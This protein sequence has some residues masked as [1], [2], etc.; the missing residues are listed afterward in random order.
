MGFKEFWNAAKQKA[1]G[2]VGRGLIGAATAVAPAIDSMLAPYT[3]GVPVVSTITNAG[4]GYLQR[5]ARESAYDRQ[6]KKNELYSQALAQSLRGEQAK[7]YVKERLGKRGFGAKMLKG[8]A[9]GQMIKLPSAQDNNT[10]NGHA[11]VGYSISPTSNKPSIASRFNS[12][13]GRKKL[14]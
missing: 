3:A 5:N 7:A 11:A 10:S 1:P 6:N 14:G 9:K 12:R 8:L 2:L 13:P 4:L